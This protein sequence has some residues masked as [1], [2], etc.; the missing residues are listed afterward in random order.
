MERKTRGEKGAKKTPNKKEEN[1]QRGAPIPR[2]TKP[3]EGREWAR[4]K[5][6]EERHGNRRNHVVPWVPK[7]AKKKRGCPEKSQRSA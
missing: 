4:K 5:Q 6:G 3:V 1:G 2:A 7:C